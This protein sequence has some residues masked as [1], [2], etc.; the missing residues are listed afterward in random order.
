MFDGLGFVFNV[1]YDDDAE[2][3]IF[4]TELDIL[5]IFTWKKVIDIGTI[6]YRTEKKLNG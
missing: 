2:G 6:I 5:M 3:S 4:D 1:G